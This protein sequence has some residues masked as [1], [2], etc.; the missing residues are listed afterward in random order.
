MAGRDGDF[1]KQS[2]FPMRQTYRRAA[3]KAIQ[4]GKKAI[5]RGSARLRQHGN[6]QSYQSYSPKMLPNSQ[7][8][9]SQD[10]PLGEWRPL[11]RASRDRRTK[12]QVACHRWSAAMNSQNEDKSPRRGS[13]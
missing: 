7:E 11:R 5:W 2:Q 1:A 6:N 3:A 4:S 8:S 10:K 12:G 9:V 13:V